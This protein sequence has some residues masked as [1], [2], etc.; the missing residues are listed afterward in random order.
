MKISPLPGFKT[1]LIII[2]LAIVSFP[3][4]AAA[5]K[6]SAKGQGKC[7]DCHRID[8][9]E[10]REI[11][12]D[13]VDEV[14]EV[15]YSEVPGLYIVDATGKNGKRGLL[16]MDFSKKFI[17][18]GTL[19]SISDRK[20]ITALEASRLRRVDPST[21]PLKDSLVVGDPDAP[22]KL[23]LFTDPQC[24]YCKKLHP[25]LEK[26]VK[27]DPRIVFYIKLMPLVSLHPDAMRISKS[28]LCQNSVDLLE[29]SFAG[30]KIPDPTCDTD[31]VE[32]TLQLSQK[33]GIDSTPTLIFPDGRM[34]SGYRPA[35]DILE[36]LKK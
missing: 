29:A 36:L 17:L 35:E 10:T 30:K 3:S 1:V 19:V 20:N 16:Y 5:F 18:A 2:A 25:E 15:G 4:D 11:L 31:A 7:S 24:P 23:I 14:H 34:L 21:I 13:F 6:A 12:K 33:L 32:K 9:S 26:V 27:A 22:V 8:I 28:I